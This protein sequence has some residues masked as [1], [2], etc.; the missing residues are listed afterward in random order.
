MIWLVYVYH[1]THPNERSKKMLKIEKVG[2][3]PEMP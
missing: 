2:T 3:E 1:R